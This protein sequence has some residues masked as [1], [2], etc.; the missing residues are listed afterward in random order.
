MVNIVSAALDGLVF[1]QIC[2]VNDV[3]TEA[4]LE[5]LRRILAALQ[6]ARP[7]RD[8]LFPR[9]GAAETELTSEFGPTACKALRRCRSCAEPF[10]H[11][12]EI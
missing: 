12:K 7:R 1:Q 4:P 6:Q 10:E 11:V 3:S 8:V 5:E 9:C 2:V